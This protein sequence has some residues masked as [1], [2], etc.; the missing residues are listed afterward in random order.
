M[1]TQ[2]AT[3]IVFVPIIIRYVGEEKYGVWTLAMAIVGVL[4]FLEF[5]LVQATN[6][7]LSAIDHRLEPAA[8]GDMACTT[9]WLTFFSGLA[10]LAIG[11]PFSGDIAELL[12]I[13]R[14]MHEEA[15]FV[16]ALIIWRF[17]LSVPLRQFNTLLISQRLMARAHLT[18]GF[19]TLVYFGAGWVMLN[20]G[21]GLV[22]L[23]WA[24]LATLVLEHAIYLDMSRA[25]LPL[26]T[27]S[28]RRFKVRLVPK[29]VEFSLFAWLGQAVN[30]VFMR[31]GVFLVQLTAG[32]VA[33]GAFG[34]ANRLILVSQELA[35]QVVFAGGPKVAKLA[36]SGETRRDS[37]WLTLA[38]AR[39]ALLLSGP[40]AAVA[41]P[42]GGVF[43]RG[44]IGGEMAEV[45]A[46][47]L[48]ILAVDVA[49]S[50]PTLTAN[51]SLT[52]SGEHRWVNLWSIIIA[53]TYLPLAYAGG[54]WFGV[55]GVATA[56][57]VVT[58][59]VGMPIFLP[60]LT[61]QTGLN[62]GL[63]WSAVYARHMLPFLVGLAF[64]YV[65]AVFTMRVIPPSRWWMAAAAAFGLL[66][67]LAYLGTYFFITAPVEERG[68]A[69][70]LW[71]KAIAR[72][73]L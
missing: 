47:P 59:V 21:W 36:A 55:T 2:L 65:A 13:P 41:V 42:L 44:W 1:A 9:F 46:A 35:S 68:W 51:N 32:L 16:I 58:V 54:L 28:P 67:V 56:S 70:D 53:A 18:Q 73:G 52:L 49:L 31:A 27:Y 22:G 23:A 34:V 62:V 40:L 64:A 66:A 48:A 25:V 61:R 33:T 3:M 7:F 4:A 14:P 71:K 11:L 10:V 69:R 63:W 8:F 20:L 60:R 19:I 24:F 15:G 17:A 43:L 72:L 26:S 37:G 39:R 29:I 57:L 50:V 12:D 30:V 6:R 45:A 38:L 5:G